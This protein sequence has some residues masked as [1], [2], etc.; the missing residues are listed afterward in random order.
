MTNSQRR[1]I[2]FPVPVSVDNDDLRQDVVDA[3]MSGMP[4]QFN[5]IHELP[6][7]DSEEVSLVER[8]TDSRYC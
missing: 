7:V 8:L 2:Y 6:E 4:G 5:R 3:M 1:Q